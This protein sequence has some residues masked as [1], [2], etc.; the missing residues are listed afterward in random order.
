[1]KDGRLPGLKNIYSLYTIRR[2]LIKKNALWIITALLTA[3]FL[4]WMY[5]VAP[6]YVCSSYL[7]S[8]VFMYFM[9]VYIS[10]NLHEK[11]NDVFEE[12]LQLHAKSKAEYYLSREM[13]QI[14][15]CLIFAL[16]L[17]FFPVIYSVIRPDYFTRNV[18]PR[19]LLCGGLMII[20]CGICGAETGDFFHPR[21]I[22]R[23]LGV[24]GAVLLSLLAVCKPGLILTSAAFRVL[25]IITPPIF[26]SLV[27][28][29]TSDS[30]DT[31]GIL[32][33]ALHMLLYSSIAAI[34]KIL[35]LNHWGRG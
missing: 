35:L 18:M 19:D 11:E 23:K 30:F 20:F 8:S 22:S 12:V 13:L 24:C 25:D 28:L 17:S 4:G 10:M 6:A 27:L 1:M 14:R 16:I 7:I 31:V 34:L 2:R 29:G 9:S 32:L 26:D 3:G 33:I 5:T 21:F 15:M